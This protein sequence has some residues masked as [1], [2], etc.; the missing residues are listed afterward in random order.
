MHISDIEV[1]KFESEFDVG[2][3]DQMKMEVPSRDSG[4]YQ[5]LLGVLAPPRHPLVHL[6]RAELFLLVV[7]ALGFDLEVDYLPED[8]GGCLSPV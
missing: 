8:A 7:P 3:R 1:G 5:E 2:R 4:N 6:A